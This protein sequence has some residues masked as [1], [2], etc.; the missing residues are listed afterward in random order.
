MLLFVSCFEL[1]HPCHYIITTNMSLCGLNF[2][3]HTYARVDLAKKKGRKKKDIQG[4]LYII[5][6]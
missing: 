1:H 5:H 2:D 3:V 6:H 4:R